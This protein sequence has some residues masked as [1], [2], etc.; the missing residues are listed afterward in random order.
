MLHEVKN[1]MIKFKCF[2]VFC[3]HMY[4]VYFFTITITLRFQIII[5]T[6]YNTLKDQYIR[7]NYV[8]FNQCMN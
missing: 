3:F 6:S 8:L 2:R 5:E 1:Q 7:R 4:I